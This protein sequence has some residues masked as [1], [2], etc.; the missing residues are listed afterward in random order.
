MME[1]HI[2]SGTGRIM[3]EAA[4]RGFVEGGGSVDSAPQASAEVH[5]PVL[6]E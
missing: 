5:S 4:Q 2:A 3:S 1:N 6:S